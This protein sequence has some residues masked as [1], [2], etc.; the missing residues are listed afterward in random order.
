MNKQNF[1]NIINNL[2][3]TDEELNKQKKYNLFM[4][5]MIILPLIVSMVLF[6]IGKTFIGF[7]V[8]F[9]GYGITIFIGINKR[10]KILNDFFRVKEVHKNIN[11][12]QT[13]DEKILKSLYE[14]SALTFL[15]Q[16]N[17]EYLDFIYNWLN[18]Q[19]VLKDKM[20]NL[21]VFNGSFIKKVYKINNYPDDIN[22]SCISLNDLNLK[23][24]DK[25]KFSEGHLII[26]SR[27]LDDII[28]NAK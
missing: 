7:T 20:L 18:N 14:N 1:F 10:K 21:Y 26:G 23:N 12:I 16:M 11:V 5:I 22:F 3:K 25:N 4:G 19:N 27:W 8:L 6:I 15:G 28:N 9:I 24:V 13:T 17:D 2:P